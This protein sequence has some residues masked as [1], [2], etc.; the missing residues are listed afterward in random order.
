MRIG[1]LF[2][3]GVVVV[4]LSIFALAQEKPVAIPDFGNWMKMGPTGVDF[5]EDQRVDINITAFMDPASDQKSQRVIQIWEAPKGRGDF[6]Y[7][8]Y[9]YIA[10]ETKEISVSYWQKKDSGWANIPSEEFEKKLADYLSS[11]GITKE[12]FEKLLNLK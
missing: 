4:L 11:I 1:K 6:A 5:N 10:A 7:L 3:V 9:L 8:I 2:V 12:N